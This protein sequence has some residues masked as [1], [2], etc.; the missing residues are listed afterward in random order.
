MPKI[1]RV[2]YEYAKDRNTDAPLNYLDFEYKINFPLALEV[3]R[4]AKAMI[5]VTYIHVDALDQ[6]GKPAYTVKTVGVRK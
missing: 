3:L 6:Y 5:N 1:Y 4:R 2:A